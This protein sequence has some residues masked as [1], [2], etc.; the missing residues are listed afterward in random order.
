VGIFSKE[1]GCKAET[2]KSRFAQAPTAQGRTPARWQIG[3]RALHPG[4]KTMYRSF[5]ELPILSVQMF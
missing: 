3:H 4:F 5:K 2:K 1:P